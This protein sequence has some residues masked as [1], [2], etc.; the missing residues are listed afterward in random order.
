M[1]YKYRIVEGKE[2]DTK[3]YEGKC[4]T[5]GCDAKNCSYNEMGSICGA[6]HIKIDGQRAICTGETCCSTFKPR[7][8]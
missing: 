8:Q 3:K 4:A 2:M 7:T 5:I 1:T 6:S